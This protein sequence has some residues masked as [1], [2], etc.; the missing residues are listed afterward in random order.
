MKGVTSPP[1]LIRAAQELIPALRPEQSELIQK[2]E[3]RPKVC[4]LQSERL[5][6]G[7]LYLPG[8]G[9]THVLDAVSPALTAWL[10]IKDLIQNQAV[11]SLVQV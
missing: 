7:I 5:E 6:D 1:L 2:E 11:P 9:S 4:K 8:H 10:S 3:I